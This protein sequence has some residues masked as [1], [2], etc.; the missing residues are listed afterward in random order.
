MW[1]YEKKH[2]ELPTGG[3]GQA[4]ELAS[5]TSEL[6]TALDVHPKLLGAGADVV[7]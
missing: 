5:I 7:R 2:G 3:E 6:Q 4:E 1:E